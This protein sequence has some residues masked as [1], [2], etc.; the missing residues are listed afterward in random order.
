MILSRSDCMGDLVDLR[1]AGRAKDQ[2]HAVEEK[3]S[4]KRAKQEVLD[5]RFGATRRLL[6]I[7]GKNVSGD[8]GDF[9]SDENDQQFDCAGEQAHADRAKGDQ[10]VEL[11]LVMA[12]FGQ[13]IE[14]EQKRY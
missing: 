9:E 13:R 8:R 3:G 1:G 10:S 2:R 12:V 5:C 11:A 4:G 7:T 6:A 14:R